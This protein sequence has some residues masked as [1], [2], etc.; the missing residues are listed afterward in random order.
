MC[1][2]VGGCSFH[3]L[4][5]H[6]SLAAVIITPPAKLPSKDLEIQQTTV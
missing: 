2:C 1:T 5:F 4:A 3:V 6:G